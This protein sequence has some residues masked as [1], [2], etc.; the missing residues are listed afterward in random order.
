MSGKKTSDKILE[1]H[2]RAMGRE[3]GSVHNA[4][5]N[6]LVSLHTRWI[7]YRQLFAQPDRIALLNEAAGFLFHVLQNVMYENV[8][9]GLAR[10]TDPPRSAGKDNLTLRRLPDLIPDASLCLE[11]EDLVQKALDACE[12]AR[13]WRNRRLAHNDLALL[14]ATSTDPLSGVSRNDI[15]GALDAFRNLV[16]RLEQHYRHSEVAYQQVVLGLGTGDSLVSYLR[17]GVQVERARRQR[18]REGR[19]LPED[20]TPEE[21]G[22]LTTV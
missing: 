1:E 20:W 21:E 12:F 15:E 18:L 22:G 5:Y 16:N 9:L 2:I 8:I 13:D 6:E 3:L 14:L 19:P 4:L 11:V 17:K 7:L 10:L